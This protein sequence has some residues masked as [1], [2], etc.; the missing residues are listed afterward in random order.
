MWDQARTA[1]QPDERLT[2]EE[3]P[4]R[5]RAFRAAVPAVVVCAGVVTVGAAPALAAGPTVSAF[6]PTSGTTGTTATIT[7]TG[8]TGAL[9][10]VC[11]G[12]TELLPKLTYLNG[13]SVLCSGEAHGLAMV[14]GLA[15]RLASGLRRIMTGAF[16]LDVRNGT[17]VLYTGRL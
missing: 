4:M 3:V 11:A 8:F 1:A 6:S 14:S 15:E 2:P 7:G 16:N 9:L 5:V 12:V 17:A 13:K 10:A